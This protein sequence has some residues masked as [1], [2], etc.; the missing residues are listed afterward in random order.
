MAK[1]SERVIVPQSLSRE[2]TKPLMSPL[3]D[4]L[5]WDA[6]ESWLLRLG[7]ADGGMGSV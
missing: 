4:A 3:P 5:D 7:E 1:T 2:L 6:F